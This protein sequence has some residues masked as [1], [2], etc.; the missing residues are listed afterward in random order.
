MHY[1]VDVT[2]N[3]LSEEH[4]CIVGSEV[5]GEELHTVTLQSRDRVLLSRIQSRHHSLGTDVDL[6]RI[7]EPVGKIQ[8]FMLLSA[9]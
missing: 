7:Q 2:E 3:N 8:V 9:V 5:L 4:E 6:I 1:T